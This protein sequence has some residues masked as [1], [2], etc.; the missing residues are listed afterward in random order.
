[1]LR[2]HHVFQ[3][4][5]L[6]EQVVELEDEPERRRSASRRACGRDRSSIRLAVEPDRAGVGRIEQA[7]HV[8]QRALARTAR[9]DHRDELA[10]VDLQ[11]D[12][13]EHRDPFF[14]LRYPSSRP[15]ADRWTRHGQSPP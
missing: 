13:M 2:H 5:Q 9:A 11:V 4:R 10:P 3:R 15:T 7:Q 8:Q 1:M 14:P 6:G 12:A